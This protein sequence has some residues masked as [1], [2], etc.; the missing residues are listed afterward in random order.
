MAI[1]GLVESHDLDSKEAKD[2]HKTAEDRGT[3]AKIVDIFN[4]SIEEQPLIRIQKAYKAIADIEYQDNPQMV[5]KLVTPRITPSVKVLKPNRDFET[6]AKLNVIK[7]IVRFCYG[8]LLAIQNSPGLKGQTKEIE[9]AQ[10]H[11]LHVT[12]KGIREINVISIQDAQQ[13]DVPYALRMNIRKNFNQVLRNI[14]PGVLKKYI[15]TVAAIRKTRLIDDAAKTIENELIALPSADVQTRLQVHKDQL[16]KIENPYLVE[17]LKYPERTGRYLTDGAFDR[18]NSIV[19]EETEETERAVLRETLQT[20][21]ITLNETE[22]SAVQRENAH[23]RKTYAELN[24]NYKTR[25]MATYEA[26]ASKYRNL[27][28]N[29]LVPGSN[30]VAMAYARLKTNQTARGLTILWSYAPD[31]DDAYG[32]TLQKLLK[33][34]EE[35][36]TAF[37]RS[38]APEMDLTLIKKSKK[39]NNDPIKVEDK[40]QAQTNFLQGDVLTQAENF[41]KADAEEMG[42]VFAE[43]AHIANPYSIKLLG[44]RKALL[45]TCWKI[46]DEFEGHPVRK[47]AFK[48]VLKKE[49]QAVNCLI[50]KLE[51][52]VIKTEAINKKIANLSILQA[53][54]CTK[55][56]PLAMK[57]SN[58]FLIVMQGIVQEFEELKR[59]KKYTGDNYAAYML[60]DVR[61]QTLVRS[62]AGFQELKPIPD[63]IKR[64]EENLNE[65]EELDPYNDQLPSFKALL[66]Q[67]KTPFEPGQNMTWQQ[68]GDIAYRWHELNSSFFLFKDGFNQEKVK[69]LK[70]LYENS[71]SELKTVVFIPPEKIEPKPIVDSKSVVDSK[72]VVVKPKQRW[73]E[74]KKARIK[75]ERIEREAKEVQERAKEQIENQQRKNKDKAYKTYSDLKE[76]EQRIDDFQ[77]EMHACLD[78]DVLKM[79][80]DPNY[81]PKPIDY[82]NLQRLVVEHSQIAVRVDKD[83]KLTPVQAIAQLS[84]TIELLDKQVIASKKLYDEL[85]EGVQKEKE[86]KL[87]NALEGT[88]RQIGLLQNAIIDDLSKLDILRLQYKKLYLKAALN[89]PVLV[90][91]VE[92][93]PNLF[94]DDLAKQQEQIKIFNMACQQQSFSAEK[95]ND[96]LVHRKLQIDVTPEDFAKIAKFK[97]VDI[98]KTP[99]QILAEHRFDRPRKSDGQLSIIQ[100]SLVEEEKSV[101]PPQQAA[102]HH[103]Y[104][105]C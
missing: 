4:L 1:T 19:W 93:Y 37:F 39:E 15:K 75:R 48:S 52:A 64:F 45:V 10:K 5:Q 73:G 49:Q 22:I 23:L 86:F 56:T 11:V 81:M 61:V 94:S 72:P 63:Q 30:D 74:S 97:R 91:L 80:F 20:M 79:N 40:V 13:N 58:N 9:I 78:D 98:H 43:H 14:V 26:R 90:A 69:A 88:A 67:L 24:D 65:L 92:K 2:G 71:S 82:L 59:L 87:K 31:D 89:N 103:R 44:K 62:F 21:G 16:P 54:M 83:T 60:L 41:L 104:T 105:I 68:V 55:F 17:L 32:Q 85:A 76:L 100:K 38:D 35:N 77:K 70:K 46:V 57:N 28:F 36:S 6:Q 101:L 34:L 42:P 95:L 96:I 27:R 99:A 12:Q 8:A 7:E 50:S 53:D 51:K 66:N 102:R 18:L 3:F 33:K 84:V 29:A 25:E 47:E